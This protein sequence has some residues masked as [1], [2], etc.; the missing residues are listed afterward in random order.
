MQSY[1]VTLSMH[2]VIG[3]INCRTNDGHLV[4]CDLNVEFDVELGSN[5]SDNVND[6]RKQYQ[7]FVKAYIEQI[8]TACGVVTREFFCENYKLFR[9][10]AVGLAIKEMDETA[11]LIRIKYN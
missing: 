3:K 6:V 8:M 4:S 11:D 7:L 1:S 2:V 5:K 9:S 10:T